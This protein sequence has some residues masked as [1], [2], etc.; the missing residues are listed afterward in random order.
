MDAGGTIPG[1]GEVERSKEPEPRVTPG[2]VTEVVALRTSI[3]VN[4]VLPK[5]ASLVL[6]ARQ[7]LVSVSNG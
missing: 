1:M 4:Q 3:E 6:V 7:N 5:P 2:A